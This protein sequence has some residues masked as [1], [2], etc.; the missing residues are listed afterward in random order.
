[1]KLDWK[2]MSELPENCRVLV[3]TPYNGK[4]DIRWISFT[5]KIE[6]GKTRRMFMGIFT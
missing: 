4:W 3:A 5:S 2:P 6:K 1:M